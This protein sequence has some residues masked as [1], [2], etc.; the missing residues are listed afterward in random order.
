MLSFSQLEFTFSAP[1]FTKSLGRDAMLEALARDL[2]GQ[3]GAARLG[4]RVQVEW[5]SRLRSAAGR[6]EYRSARVLL[7]HRLC[8]HGEGEIDRTLRHELAHL[9][10]QFRAGRRRVA[11]HGAEWRRACADLAIGGESRCHTLPFPIRRQ[12]LRYLY[13]CPHCKQDFPRTRLVKR[14]TACLSCCRAFNR[15]EYDGRFRL[16]LGNR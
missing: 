15:G 5:S 13:F 10:A 7:N 9:L 6:A 1:L 14:R 2:L 3:N 8:A 16:R 11:P 4:A 12:P